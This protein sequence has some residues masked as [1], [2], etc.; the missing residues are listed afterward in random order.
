ML[1]VECGSEGLVLK[2]VATK[3]A[4]L[5]IMIKWVRVILLLNL[6]SHPFVANFGDTSG[7][8]TDVRAYFISGEKSSFAFLERMRDFVCDYFSSG[9]FSLK[10]LSH[11]SKR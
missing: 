9:I 8:N 3:T 2:F 4:R 5:A 11:I 10:K 1:L 6:H 7:F